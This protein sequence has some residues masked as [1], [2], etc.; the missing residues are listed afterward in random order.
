MFRTLQC[1]VLAFLILLVLPTQAQNAPPAA[2]AS[3]EG[4]TAF[5]FWLGDWQVTTNDD[6]EKFLGTNSITK[7]YGDCLIMEHWKGADGS[8]EWLRDVDFSRTRAYALGLTGMFI[9]M[10]GREGQGIV[11]PGEEA[12]A[13]A[14]RLDEVGHLEGGPAHR[15]FSLRERLASAGLD[16]D[17][18]SIGL[19][20]EC[21]CRCERCR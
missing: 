17:S 10:E 12:E 16:R 4:F 11:K 18:F 7:H 9:N 3:G 8:A 19:A 2:C 13:L 20:M 14:L 21:R 6:D 5:D 15:F 1:A